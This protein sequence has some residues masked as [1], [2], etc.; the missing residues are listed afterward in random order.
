MPAALVSMVG[1]TTR[2]RMSA[3]MPPEKSMRGSGSGV[4]SSVASQ[5]TKATAN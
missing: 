4:A 3:G 5:F 2:V 1:V